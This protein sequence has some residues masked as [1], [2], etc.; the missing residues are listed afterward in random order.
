[1]AKWLAGSWTPARCALWRTLPP[2]RQIKMVQWVYN[3]GR[4]GVCYS[5]EIPDN[6]NKGL[7]S[8]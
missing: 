3:E 4:R 6:I 8:E 7:Q 1:M 2:D 5:E